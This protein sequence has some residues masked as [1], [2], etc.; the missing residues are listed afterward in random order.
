MKVVEKQYVVFT[1]NVLR[2]LHLIRYSQE[3]QEPLHY[4]ND[5]RRLS[6]LYST[7]QRICVRTR[8]SQTDLVL[9]CR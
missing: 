1:I 3:I 7:R 4:I 9:E 6:L 2:S 5:S 8:G